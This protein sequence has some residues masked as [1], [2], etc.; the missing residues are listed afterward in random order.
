[1]L[2]WVV[3]KS[4][5]IKKCFNGNTQNNEEVNALIWKRPKA[6]C[7]SLTVLEI[8]TASVVIY[9]NDGMVG[10]LRCLSKLGITPGSNSFDYCNNKRDITGSNSIDYCNKR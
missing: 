10:M 5:E 1:M 4:L 8:G 3:I 9:F 6:I 2:E 7:V